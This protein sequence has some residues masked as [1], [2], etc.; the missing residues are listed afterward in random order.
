MINVSDL[1]FSYRQTPVLNIPA[2]QV[3]PGE[4]ILLSGESGSGK[5]TLLHL[6]AGLNQPDSGQVEIGGQ[7]LTAMSSRKVDQYRAKNI[8]FISQRLNLIPYLSVLDNVLLAAKL[9]GSKSART[10]L[11]KQAGNLLQQVNLDSH[12]H[13]Q[14]AENLSIGQQQRVAIVRAFIH[15]PVVMLADEPTSALDNTNRD[16]F[17]TLLHSLCQQH[18]TTLVMVSHDLSLTTGF[19]HHLALA[20]INK[21]QPKQVQ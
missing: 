14:K 18:K 13:H 12:L 17:M 10:E 9:S 21:I 1:T 7:G 6:L 11:I 5:S 19:D 20:D 4:R 2:W 16:S 15:Q 3:Q 8:G